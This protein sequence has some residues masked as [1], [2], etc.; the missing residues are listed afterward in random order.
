MNCDNFYNNFVEKFNRC[1]SFT[2]SSTVSS[3]IAEEIIKNYEIEKEKNNSVGNSSL[4]LHNKIQ[5]DN[6]EGIHVGDII[7]YYY[8]TPSV[9]GMNLITQ[10][11]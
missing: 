7:N 4:K 10:V 3:S 6:S 9:E 11:Y 8:Q 5:F 1:D 2:S